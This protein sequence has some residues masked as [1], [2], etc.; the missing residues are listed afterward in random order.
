MKFLCSMVLA[1]TLFG[2]ANVAPVNPGEYQVGERLLVKPDNAWNEVSLISTDSIKTWTIDGLPLDQL[3]IY[4]GI[5][6]GERLN[7]KASVDVKPV[8]FR[9]NMRAD[10][11]VGMFEAVMTSIGATMTVTKLE[12]TTFAGNKG[13]RFEYEM[14]QQGAEVRMRGVGYGTIQQERLFAIVFWAPRLGMYPKYISRVEQLV[15]SAQL[16]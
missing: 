2:C 9:A 14:V 10:E 8:V 15:A 16:R 1:L 6:D 4:S 11:V 7:P 5:Q 3:I 13:F 12:P